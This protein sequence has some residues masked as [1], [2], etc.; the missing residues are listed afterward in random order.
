[1]DADTLGDVLQ[2]VGAVIATVGLTSGLGEGWS[3]FGEWADGLQRQANS[4]PDEP[5]VKHGTDEFS[6][7]DH[8]WVLKSDEDP[9][10]GL[11]GDLQ[12]ISNDVA[13]TDDLI[14]S[15]IAELDVAGQI[16]TLRREILDST[17]WERRA[18]L[19]GAVV[20]ILGMVVGLCG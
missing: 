15:A 19:G 1:M 4:S 8:A 18:A 14:R 7:T 16:K 9:I 20:A 3:A 6:A 13:G 11:R 12:R 5:V 17:K 2:L 10:D